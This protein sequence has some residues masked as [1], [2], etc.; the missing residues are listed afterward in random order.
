MTFLPNSNHSYHSTQIL[1]RS[2][3]N[4]WGRVKSLTHACFKELC[5]DFFRSTLDSVETELHNSKINKS[6]S[7]KSSWLVVPLIVK[8]VFFFPTSSTARNPTRVSTLM[9]LLLMAWLS[10]L[11]SPLATLRRLKTFSA[12]H[13]FPLVLRL[14]EVSR[15]PSSLS[16]SITLPVLHFTW[17]YSFL[18]FYY[19]F[20]CLGLDVL[21]ADL[22]YKSLVKS[23]YWVPNM[24]TETITG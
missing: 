14:L 11:L 21:L 20:I 1:P 7:M 6:T 10:R 12:L 4:Q 23:G 2:R 22:V 19:L 5:Q 16:S 8:L 3:R 24:V 9:R 13:L 17:S 18:C 15:L